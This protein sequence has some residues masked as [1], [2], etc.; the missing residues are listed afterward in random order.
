[1]HSILKLKGEKGMEKEINIKNIQ[2]KWVA[3]FW[4][5]KP[6]EFLTPAEAL[7]K[8]EESPQSYRLVL[9]EKTGKYSLVICN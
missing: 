6:V 8:V 3:V 5:G 7:R 1:M 4:H 2:Q 9:D